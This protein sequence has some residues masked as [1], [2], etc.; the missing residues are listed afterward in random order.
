MLKKKKIP[1]ALKIFADDKKGSISITAR[2]G[3]IFRMRETKAKFH[4]I[5]Q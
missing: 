1:F 2:R 5:I 4:L 3:I